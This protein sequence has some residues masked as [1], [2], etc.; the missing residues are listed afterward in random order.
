[1]PTIPIDGI[2]LYYET[3]GEGEP[4]ALLNG[5]LMT[6]E[7][8]A[9]QTEV[10]ERRY[11]L[12]LHDFRGQL[13]SPLGQERDPEDRVSGALG[14]CPSIRTTPSKVGLGQERDPEDRV[15]GALG[16]R[17]LSF[18]RH[19]E[20][21]A[22][23]LDHLEVES[24]H[25]VGTS[26]GGEVGMLFAASHPQR[27]RSLSVIASVSRPEALLVEQV[28]CWA[29]IAAADPRALYR[30]VAPTVFSNRFLIDSAAVIA[31]GEARLGE[32]PEG[33]FADFRKLVAAFQ[34]LDLTEKLAA[35]T[36]PTLVV[37][38]EEDALKPVHYSRAIADAVAGAE[39][40]IV[41]GAGHAV[42]LEKAGEVNT[43]LLG[44]LEK[45]REA[46]DQLASS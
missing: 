28:G 41:P 42:V 10:L 25:L 38:G 14:V 37:C 11:R 35:I 36:S 24:C 17:D 23:F 30:F 7:S 40:L 45:H 13:R 31:L 8:W 15:S 22:A 12:I 39:L 26:Y 33:F 6:T 21:L 3:R 20:D 1:M 4:V 46:G 43:A 18:E 19:V 32:A 2:E 27:V 44:F 34:Q 16:E 9:F 5:V 29:E